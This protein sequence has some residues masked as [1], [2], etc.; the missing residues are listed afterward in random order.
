MADDLLK[1]YTFRREREAAWRELDELVVKSEKKGIRSLEAREM[2]RL[3]LLYRATLSSLSVARGISL[4]RN[5]LTYLENL[6]ARAY[7]CVYGARGSF[8]VSA[9]HF[10]TTGFPS[11]VRAGAWH[12]VIATLFLCLGI[13]TGY[14]LTLDQPDWYYTFVSDAMADGRT[15]ASTREDLLEVL[16]NTPDSAK[17]HLNIFAT[18]L[19][20]HNATIGILAFALGI[21]LGIP[22]AVLLT[23]NG[24]IIGAMAGLH[25][26]RDL[27]YDFWG[28]IFVHGTTELLAV[29]LCGGAG[30]MLGSAMVLPGRYSRMDNLAQQ[31]RAA[32]RIVIGTVMLFL[33]AGMLE[34]FVRQLVTDPVLRYS[35]GTGALVFWLVYFYTAGRGRGAEREP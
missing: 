2:Y 6:S 23:Y 13:A 7:L 22:V 32:G 19:F 5:V 26:S 10:F 29:V 17:E 27:S 30:L 15:P 3:P 11:A 14:F 31:G 9:R 20:T 33:V 34:G 12:V 18:F 8:L 21:A 28:W 4:D 16:Y 1:S 24:I 35:I 25:E